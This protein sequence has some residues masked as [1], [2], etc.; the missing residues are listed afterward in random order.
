MKITICGTG[1][2]ATA[3][4][5]VLAKNKHQIT[6]YGID[7]EEIKNINSGKN[8]EYFSE[9]FKY[10][11][12]NATNNLET[13]LKD[14][15]LV[16]LAIPSQQI[17]NVLS[18]LADVLKNKKINIVNV[19]KGLDGKSTSFYSVLI[20][21]NFSKNL[22]ML[23]TIIGP[24]YAHE[25]Y[26][27]Q[28]TAIN[29]VGNNYDYLKE[30]KNIFQTDKFILIPST[31]EHGLEMFSAMKNVLAI[32]IGI[33]KF[34][35]SSSMNPISAL[36]AIGFKEM[37]LIYKTLYPLE[38]DAIGY[39]LAAIGDAFLTCSSFKSRNTQFGYNVAKLGVKQALATNKA[40]IEG[41]VNA[42]FIDNIIKNEKINVPFISSIIDILYFD[43]EPETIF[44]FLE[45]ENYD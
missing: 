37:Y 31:K 1:A 6:M 30:L 41:Y 26:D 24:S 21:K 14:T 10:K 18:Q 27:E 9:P 44:D 8:P 35:Y 4:A 15:K 20:R 33:A 12:I 13:A 38:S 34:Y 16:V 3:L 28:L 11:N 45:K 40:T 19:A 36:F 25:V 42:K 39:D 17:I 43:K 2:W 29:V 7:E 22:N 23:A 32:G 5:T